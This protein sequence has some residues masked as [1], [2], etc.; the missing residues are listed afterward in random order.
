M[1]APPKETALNHL[2]PENCE[3]SKAGGGHAEPARVHDDSEVTL[4]HLR[5]VPASAPLAPI[6]SSAT[7][8]RRERRATPMSTVLHVSPRR[9]RATLT[10]LSGTDPGCVLA[11]QEREVIL[12]R[13]RDVTLSI[14][15]PSIS[16]R[17]ARIFQTDGGRHLLEDLGSTNGTF[18][19]GR[20]VCRVA[21]ESGD[22]IQ[23]GPDLILLFSL[24]DEREDVLKRQ[25]YEASTRDALTGLTNRRRLLHLLEVEVARGRVDGDD[26][27]LL[28][29]DVDNFKRIN[30]TFGHLAGDHVLRA[31]AMS[32]SKILRAGDVLA[33]YGGEEFVAVISGATRDDLIVLAERVRHSFAELRVEIGAGTVS[34]TVSVGADLWSECA[35]AVN[36]LDLLALA[37]GRMYGAKLAGRNGVC[38]HAIAAA[39]AR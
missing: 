14:D 27:G 8:E 15:D 37:D 38:A 23:L 39:I 31:L 1:F 33:R 9:D 36:Y 21:L 35:P 13:A 34:A 6:A 16:R 3:S 20:V 29:I 10:V 18:V 7:F 30:D 19:N 5:T 4:S 2:Q 28:M 25:L 22:R 12:G 24:V 11:L 32:A 26:I 17:H